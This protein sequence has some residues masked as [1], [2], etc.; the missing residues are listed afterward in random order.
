MPKKPTIPFGH[1]KFGRD[2]SV[3]KHIETLP[4]LKA[5]Q[6][7]EI[8]VRFA[9][10]LEIAKGSAFTCASRN[11]DDHDFTLNGT[12]IVQ[13]TEIVARDFL[14]PLRNGEPHN[15][16]SIVFTANGQTWGED[17]KAKER[18][19]LERIQGKLQKSYSKPR[20]PL[21]LLVWTV[22]DYIPC[23]QEDGVMRIFPGVST[24]TD[25]LR[26]HGASPFDEVWFF[27]PDLRPIRLWPTLE[28]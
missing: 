27:K 25:F 4:D 14:H 11:E 21:W 13:A 6:E 5:D 15:F 12:I 24:A 22:A 16:R 28:L 19:L 23:W 1:I 3:R 18:I 7:A 17:T 26:E 2:G 10:R 20:N 9:R 8:G